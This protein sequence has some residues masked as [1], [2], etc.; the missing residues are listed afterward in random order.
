MRPPLIALLFLSLLLNSTFAIAVPTGGFSTSDLPTVPSP[1]MDA[2]TRL[3][4]ENTIGGPAEIPFSVPSAEDTYTTVSFQAAD[5][6]NAAMCRISELSASEVQRLKDTVLTPGLVGSEISAGTPPNPSRENVTDQ[7]T[8]LVPNPGDNQ[9]AFQ[10]DIPTGILQPSELSPLQNQHIKGPFA[11]GLSIN[12]TLRAAQCGDDESCAVQGESLQLRNSGQG[13]TGNVKDIFNAVTN[14][15]SKPNPSFSAEESDYLNA[16]IAGEQLLETEDANHINVQSFSRVPTTDLMN[17]I[18]ADN[19]IE[20]GLLTNCENGK[21]TI[22]L[23]SMFDKYFNSWFSGE[24]VVSTFGPTLWGQFRKMLVKSKRSNLLPAKVTDFDLTKIWKNKNVAGKLGNLKG[25][26]IGP[27]D[28]FAKLDIKGKDVLANYKRSLLRDA[29]AT[30]AFDSLLRER[31]LLSI[32]SSAGFEDAAFGPNGVFGKIKDIETRQKVTA[33]LGKMREH[34]TVADEMRTVIKNGLKGK[35]VTNTEAARWYAK[36]GKDFDDAWNLDLIEV[37]RTDPATGFDKIFVK[38]NSGEIVSL[39]GEES[40]YFRDFLYE[41]FIDKGGFKEVSQLEK[42]TP[43]ELDGGLVKNAIIQ[44]EAIQIY[45]FESGTFVGTFDIAKFEKGQYTGATALLSTQGPVPVSKANLKRI[46]E[47]EKISGRPVQIVQGQFIA[48]NEKLDADAFATFLMNGDVVP[49]KIGNVQKTVNNLYNT[50]V[51]R[52]WAKGNYTNLLS[53]QL[54]TQENFVKNY[55][56]L[57]NPNVLESGVGWTAKMYGYWW[58]TRGI[59]SDKFSIYQLPKEWTEVRFV[60]GESDVYEGA[61]VDFFSNEGSDTGDI[62]QSV[63][64][65]FPVPLVLGEFAKEYPTLDSAWN[66]LNASKGRA[67]PDNLA[68][69]LFGSESCPGCAAAIHSPSKDRFDVQYLSPESVN[70]FFIEHGTSEDA[71]ERGQYLQ[72]FAHKTNVEGQMKGE[73]LDSIDLVKARAEGTTCQQV[74]EELFLYGSVAKLLGAEKTGAILGATE[75]L[76]YYSLGMMGVFVTVANQLAIA[77]KMQDC[78]DDQEGYFAS[79]FVPKPSE[80]P[81]DQAK[82]DNLQKSVSQNALDGIRAFANQIDANHSSPS[83]TDKALHEATGKVK[84]LVDDAQKTNV[85]EAELRVTGG[86]SGYLKSSEVIYFWVAGGDLISPNVYSTEGKTVV[87]T[88]DGHTIT[89]DNASGTV[90]VD[91]QVVVDPEHADHER[92]A[93]KNLSIPAIEIPQRL[94]GYHLSDTNQWLLSVN[95]RGETIVQ[96]PA[97]LDCIQQAVLDQSGVPLNSNNMSEAFGNAESVSTDAYPN[98]AIDSVKNRIL[99]GGQSPQTASGAGA[100][101]NVFGDRSVVVT[102]APNPKAG[103]LQSIQLEDGSILYKPQTNELIIWLRH[104]A[105]AVVKDSEVKNFAGTLTT[106]QNENTQCDEPAVNLRVETDP[107]TPA[108][109]LN[110]D[111]LTAGLQK[112][113]PFQVFETD[114]KRFV[115]YSKL[116]EGECVPY[117]KVINKITGDVYDQPITDISQAEDGTITIRTGDGQVHTLKFSNQ[118]GKPVITYDGNS[119]LL[120]SAQGKG[121]SFYYDPSTGQYFAENAQLIPLN[122]NFKNQGVSFQ[123]NPDGTASGKPGDNVFVINPSQGGQ[124]LFNIPSIPENMAGALLVV[125]MLCI[126]CA[127]I[128]LDARKRKN[129]L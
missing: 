50:A 107:S 37:F 19:T 71:R 114:S 111:N 3:K 121:G 1:A 64:S 72:L 66:F 16:Q 94:N 27:N 24:M 13:I 60:P 117:F 35:T 49:S 104:H 123:A 91:G 34:T 20:A 11:F 45:K 128:Y 14:D 86:S 88:A 129:V 74:S 62:F 31:K 113:G 90:I 73:A 5:G 21:C 7:N 103:K 63:I 44:P 26:V 109:K 115:L 29:D 55:F 78:V 95:I 81:A 79:L 80:K 52:D 70:G 56:N 120:R 116:V 84:E 42:F 125:L 46:L 59:G 101:I 87:S 75:A 82:A 47:D 98:I 119:E 41:P 58:L 39:G 6:S 4:N 38:T 93:A 68:V 85:A 108:T 67:Q 105:G 8:L 36:I 122:D 57:F 112:N 99:L 61:Y 9:T 12:D 53:K 97:L 17:Y 106:T 100:S 76:S 33:F 30:E 22:A 92:L 10:K 40:K 28:F 102:G 124:G 15:L 89:L 25:D 127:G 77:P 48:S 69:Y 110:G 118:N 2:F 18:R 32:G 43:R 96:D 65:K 126:V 83:L 23:Y 51:A 54:Q